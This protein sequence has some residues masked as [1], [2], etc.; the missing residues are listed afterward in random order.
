MPVSLGANRA[1]S[2]STRVVEAR[3]GAPDRLA[4]V[5]A[6]HRLGR[7]EQQRGRPVGRWGSRF[8][9]GGHDLDR[10]RK[11][12]A[13]ARRARRSCTARAARTA[14]RPASC[15]PHSPTASSNVNACREREQVAQVRE[16]ALERDRD[17]RHV[18]RCRP[19]AACAAAPRIASASRCGL[20]GLA[21]RL[22][23]HPPQ[24][25]RQRR[26]AVA[27]ALLGGEPLVQPLRRRAEAPVLEQPREQL[28]GGLLRARG[29][30]P[31]SPRPG[32]ISRDFSSSRAAI[33]I[34][35][36]VAASRSSSP[37]SSSRST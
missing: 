31:P 20:V 4:Q 10:R 13:G 26:G 33:R 2:S 12:R 30:G 16:P 3:L 5:G 23:R 11:S 24:L 21:G 29:R 14:S 1:R 22:E 32:S 37:R 35:N 8:G 36:S 7:A 27:V 6:A 34:R 17:P 28:L 25:R 18:A 15:G 19:A 9:L